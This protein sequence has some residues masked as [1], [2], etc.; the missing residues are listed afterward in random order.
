MET[1]NK[2][3][4]TYWVIGWRNL[5]EK[6]ITYFPKYG[7]S[8]KDLKK[9]L[10]FESEPRCSFTICPGCTSHAIKITEPIYK[11]GDI[12]V[13]KSGGVFIFDRYDNH[14]EIVYDKAFL[15][16]I[17]G[18]SAETGVTGTFGY[19]SGFASLEQK[20]LLFST[21]EKEGKRWNAEK[22]VIEK[23]PVV[24]SIEFTVKLDQKG[25]NDLN[26]TLEKI[27]ESA[28]EYE[29]S[30]VN[31]I[32]ETIEKSAVRAAAYTALEGHMEQIKK[33]RDDKKRAEEL[34]Q[35]LKDMLKPK[36][37]L[38]EKNILENYEIESYKY[39]EPTSVCVDG[40]VQFMCPSNNLIVT[41]KHRSK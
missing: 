39:G 40:H 11:E 16:P 25:L 17:G 36:P 19:I 9:A 33:D 41:Y 27:R 12:L 21:L 37:S 4:R 38:L 31:L 1:K 6:D 23:I 15:W 10:I 35:G 28:S 8:T 32:N 20:Q 18:F 29:K 30:I 13:T 2:N 7:V 26:D 34:F 5:Y 14:V 24:G 22:L 3:E